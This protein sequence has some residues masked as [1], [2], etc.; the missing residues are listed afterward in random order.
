MDAPVATEFLALVEDSEL[1]PAEQLRAAVETLQLD[2][3]ETGE[4]AAKRLVKAGLLTRFQAGRILN[5]RAR[6]FYFDRYKI[7]DALGFGGMSR[8]YLAEDANTGDRV[9]LKVLAERYEHD[10]GMITR[11]KLEA[12]VGMKVRHPNVLRTTHLGEAAGARYLVMENAAGVELAELIDN[13]GPVPFAQACDFI[14]QAA[15]GLHAAHQADIVHRDVKPANLLIDREG[16]VKILDFGLALPGKESADEEFSLAMIFGHDC[17]GTAYYMPPEQSLNSNDVDARADVYGLG[18]TFFHA[19][20][21]RVPFPLDDATRRGAISELLANQRNK[22]PPDVRRFAPDVPDE[23][24]AILDR[25]LAKRREDRFPSAAAVA[26]ALAPF[27]RREPIDVDVQKILADRVARARRRL[28]ASKTQRSR[29]RGGSQTGASGLGRSGS[30][31]DTE[32]NHSHDTH[33]DG[34][35]RSHFDTMQADSEDWVAALA[36]AKATQEFRPALSQDQNPAVPLTLLIPAAG[37]QPISLAKPRIVIGRDEACDV[38]VSTGQVS[39]RHCELR[40][41][42]GQWRA[43]DLESKNGIRVNGKA[44]K[45]CV[46]RSGDRLMIAEYVRYRI[47]YRDGR[48]SRTGLWLAALAGLAAAGAAGWWALAGFPLP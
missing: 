42:D 32:V 46:L 26:E 33:A 10:A 1:L 3:C 40:F 45:N 25:M 4:D 29:P 43:V 47:A 13:R 34:R 36:D 6:G 7:L 16:C 9:A 41:E 28:A 15:L 21:G 23:V 37:G 18:C 19:L 20:A 24:V 27:A 22:P 17:L 31:V 11:L 48:T 8:V 44:V 35:L 5:G 30:R 2:Q 12:L 14:R 39:G 38:V